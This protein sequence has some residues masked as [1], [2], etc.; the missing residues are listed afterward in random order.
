MKWQ[1]RFSEKAGFFL[2]TAP[3]VFLNLKKSV[4][5]QIFTMILR[6]TAVI[7][8]VAFAS[9]RIAG[10]AAHDIK[11]VR[12]QGIPNF[13]GVCLYSFMCQHSLP[14]MVNFVQNKNAQ[15]NYWIL[16]SM[17]GALVFYLA[18]LLTSTT[19][20]TGDELFPIY[21]MNFDGEGDTVIHQFIYYYL[22]IFPTIALSAS[23][24]IVGITLR[25]NLI[26]LT[27][28]M[29]GGPMNSGAKTW[30]Y[31][32]LAILPSFILVTI[33]PDKV[34]LFAGYVG[35][36]AGS[37]VQYFI[38]ACLV[39]AARRTI[40]REFPSVELS[41]NTH[42]VKMLRNTVAPCLVLAWTF[43]GIGIVTYYYITR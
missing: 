12:I 14:S 41:K 1:N 42:S 37:F 27:E 21:S 33:L 30:I 5:V 29:L 8:M 32:L 17:T 31:P 39:I 6:L 20:F 23:Y 4:F 34:S 15:F 38:P 43:I 13:F 19:A 9:V 2:V 22:M 35:A 36:Y 28:I 24:P 40:A 16:L 11:A 7:I 3:F 25:E 18:T 10:N 26:S